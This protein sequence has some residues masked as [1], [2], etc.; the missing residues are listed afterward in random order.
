MRR[1]LAVAAFALILL[2]PPAALAAAPTNAQLAAQIKALQAKVAKQDKTIKKLQTD[3]DDAGG[4]AA[5]DLAFAACG[6]AIAADALQGTFSVVDQ[7]SVNTPN[8]ARTFFG[9][10][11]PVNDSGACAALK[12]IRTQAV[13][14]TTAAFSAVLSLLSASSVFDSARAFGR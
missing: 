10:Q 12:V 9:P 3:V 7:I 6:L 5:A 4:L 11:V 8:I 1:A 2:V 14:P 13:P